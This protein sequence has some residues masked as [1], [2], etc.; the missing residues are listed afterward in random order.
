MI[1]LMRT[2][3]VFVMFNVEH[4]LFIECCELLFGTC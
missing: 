1:L 4:S 3:W 2:L